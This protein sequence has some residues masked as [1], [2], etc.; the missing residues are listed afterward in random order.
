MTIGLSKGIQCHESLLTIFQ[1]TKW[2]TRSKGSQ[3][4]DADDHFDVPA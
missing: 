4:S 1:T 2:D 3:S